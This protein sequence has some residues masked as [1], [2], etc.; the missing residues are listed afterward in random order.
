MAETSYDELRIGN[1]IEIQAKRFA[2]DFLRDNHQSASDY[3]RSRIHSQ[4]EAEK[5]E[6]LILAF[7]KEKMN[8]IPMSGL[9]VT[10]ENKDSLVIRYTLR[11]DVSI[12]N[13]EVIIAEW[14][15]AKT[16]MDFMS[17]ELAARNPSEALNAILEK[18][19]VIHTITMEE[20]ARDPKFKRMPEDCLIVEHSPLDDVIEKIQEQDL[21]P[22]PFTIP[23]ISA[24]DLNAR[25]DELEM[26]YTE[27][28]KVLSLHHKTVE[29]WTR[30]GVCQE[31]KSSVHKALT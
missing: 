15:A 13:A 18:A 9:H 27:L 4:M 23:D 6:E 16:N 21:T 14:N 11:D 3:E 22:S 7:N 2:D 8:Q 25:L 31:H 17:G 29:K 5:R 28:A 19:L 26:S 24:D 1:V 20:A 30:E 10:E 12:E